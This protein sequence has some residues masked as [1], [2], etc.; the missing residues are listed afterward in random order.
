MSGGQ[1][2]SS[3]ARG[4]LRV[5]ASVADTRLKSQRFIPLIYR[6]CKQSPSLTLW[7]ISACPV[8]NSL[9][10]TGGLRL[11]ACRIL[12]TTISSQSRQEIFP[13]M[14]D[15]QPSPKSTD[16]IDTPP[17]KTP[18]EK[19]VNAE[20]LVE[21]SE[22]SAAEN[23]NEK[24]SSPSRGNQENRKSKKVPF[25][26]KIP[27]Q[28]KNFLK[29]TLIISLT[30]IITCGLF[31]NSEDI[32]YRLLIAISS[33]T[34]IGLS[35]NTY[36][37]LLKSIIN[38]TF[39]SI[40]FPIIIF[41]LPVA[42]FIL[43]SWI[44]VIGLSGGY[45]LLS[46][47]NSLFSDSTIPFV[48]FVISAPYLFMGLLVWDIHNNKSTNFTPS[49]TSS[50]KEDAASK[51]NTL[52]TKILSLIKGQIRVLLT[53]FPVS[54]VASFIFVLYH[55]K[56][57]ADGDLGL[58][59]QITSALFPE[60]KTTWAAIT[61]AFLLIFYISFMPAI[62]LK[63][64][65]PAVIKTPSYQ[66]NK[67]D[68]YN[69]YIKLLGIA[70]SL[71][72]FSNII[73]IHIFKLVTEGNIAINIF[74]MTAMSIIMCFLPIYQTITSQFKQANTTSSNTISTK[75]FKGFLYAIVAII[76]L[77]AYSRASFFIFEYVP[78]GIGGIVANPGATIEANE[79]DYA[80]I[81]PK[82]ENNPKSIAFGVIVSSDHSSIHLFTPSYDTKN[83]RYAELLKDGHK[84]PNKLVES[85][86]KYTNGFYIEKY[87]RKIHTYNENSGQ[88]VYKTSPSIYIPVPGTH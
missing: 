2:S 52:T 55:N 1:A 66:K 34:T 26:Q 11:L 83:K 15:N 35:I 57:L 4:A 73:V 51:N 13:F 10:F 5:G 79:S 36:R 59:L 80:C 48:M 82:G 76:I 74:L 45:N 58:A 3:V 53:L 86:I 29:F 28:I 47:M 32:A 65:E 77:I 42:L 60:N 39:F 68:S 44:L 88:C 78:K 16:P 62:S 61:L 31:N 67:K 19:S 9:T 30:L 56:E 23:Q 72:T 84:K 22:N 21:S 25:Y 24:I 49:E 38:Y 81:F 14:K 41:A 6:V 18:K 71:T 50:S 27:Q 12:I 63:K 64:I 40:L 85:R 54:T 70:A 17:D 20:T 75:I 37:E 87:D 7:D 33:I 43:I 8:R 69:L 46:E